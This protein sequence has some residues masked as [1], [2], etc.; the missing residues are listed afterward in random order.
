MKPSRHIWCARDGAP[1]GESL[2]D[3]AARV[4]PYYIQEIC[5]RF[6]GQAGSDAALANAARWSWCSNGYRPAIFSSEIGTGIPL[7]YR[8]NAAPPWPRRSI[9]PRESCALLER[10][11]LE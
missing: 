5:R 8:L 6:C 10:R 4:L 2:K 11:L 1:G 3:T 7:I 9:S